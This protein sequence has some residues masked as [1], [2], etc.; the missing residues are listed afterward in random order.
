MPNHIHKNKATP[1]KSRFSKQI[2]STKF[3]Q[4]KST[5]ANHFFSYFSQKLPT[6]YLS[7]ILRACR[8]LK[9]ARF[10]L[11]YATIFNKYYVFPMLIVISLLLFKTRIFALLVAPTILKIAFLKKSIIKTTVFKSSF[12]SQI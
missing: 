2:A 7:T 9:N 8:H 4:L 11:N 12:S 5:R 10:Y 1:T 3:T 6:E